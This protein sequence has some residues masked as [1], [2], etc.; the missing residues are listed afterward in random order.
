MQ[1]APFRFSLFVPGLQILV[2]DRATGTAKMSAPKPIGKGSLDRGGHKYKKP[3]TLG[4]KQETYDWINKIVGLAKVERNKII[5]ECRQAKLED[6]FPYR[7]AVQCSALFVYE[8]PA[9]QP[10]GSPVVGQGVNGITDTDKLQR[11]IGDAIGYPAPISNWGKYPRAEIIADDRLIVDWVWAGRRYL[12]QIEW[13]AAVPRGAGVYFLLE[14]C[15][16]SKPIK[17]SRFV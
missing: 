11:A 4:D 16:D 1:P 7:K 8:R 3:G 10:E 6:P 17:I 5:N 2:K 15:D 14:P 12:D 13:D 9:S